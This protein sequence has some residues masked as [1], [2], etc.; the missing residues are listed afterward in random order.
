MFISYLAAVWVS[1]LCKLTLH[2]SPKIVG[3]C[4]D[5]KC[6]PENGLIGKQAWIS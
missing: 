6:R 1:P 4:L 5:A 2:G 3:S